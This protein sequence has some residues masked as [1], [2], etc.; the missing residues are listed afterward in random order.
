MR[1]ARTSAGTT[2]RARPAYEGG[3]LDNHD[4]PVFTYSHSGGRCSIT[5]GYVVRDKDLG[6]GIRGR[7]IYGDLCTGEI[8]S[9]RAGTG[10]VSSSDGTGLSEGGL[11]SFGTDARENVYVVAGGTVYPHRAL[12]AGSSPAGLVELRTA[13]TFVDE[14]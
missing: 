10:S 1:R 14:R 5:G 7:Y 9:I 12:G 6:G 3:P 4:K 13:A 8:R 2:S 11:V